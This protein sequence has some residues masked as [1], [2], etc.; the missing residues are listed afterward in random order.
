MNQDFGHPQDG[1]FEIVVS[2]NCSTDDIRGVV[3]QFPN[4]SIRYERTDQYVSM[5]E[6][7]EFALTKARG[8]YIGVLCTDDG[9]LPNLLST[10][11]RIIKSSKVSCIS[12][13]H[14][15][16]LWPSFFDKER[17]GMLFVPKHI[18][19]DGIR[20]SHELVEQAFT[21]MDYSKL[22]CLL[23]SF[24]SAEVFDEIRLRDGK[25]FRSYCPDVYSGFLIARTVSSLYV[26]GQLLGIAGSSGGSN[27]ATFA[28]NPLSKESQE[29][30]KMHHGEK[31]F[32][33][34]IEM[35]YPFVSMYILDS[36][37]KAFKITGEKE[38]LNR[39][40]Y[41]AYVMACFAEATG[42]KDSERQ[43]IALK[44]IENFIAH[45]DAKLQAQMKWRIREQKVKR[46][47]RKNLGL[48]G[49]RLL[50]RTAHVLGLTSG[51]LEPRQFSPDVTHAETIYDASLFVNNLLN[52]K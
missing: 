20:D 25:I 52:S 44:A 9:Y 27:G 26:T 24:C 13:Q 48:K 29:F 4:G 17:S 51:K 10:M 50:Q 3:A 34:E 15:L 16:Y 12:F 2:D 47:I 11:A 49:I 37:M 31:L 33:G 38:P 8:Q 43:A 14:A 46:I 32:S 18:F 23:N 19:K 39:V 30:L 21:T 1:H 40:N 45:Q 7:W 35:D 6:S 28:K 22:P 41:S 5:C 36:A 42:I